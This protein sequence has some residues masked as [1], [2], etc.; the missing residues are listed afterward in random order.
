MSCK[1]RHLVLYNQCV[2]ILPKVGH[3]R[4][5]VQTRNILVQ[6]PFLLNH[7]KF[8][9]RTIAALQG[10]N[11]LCGGDIDKDG[12]HVR[13][14]ARGSHINT[15]HF[16]D[17][18]ERVRC[19]IPDFMK[20]FLGNYTLID[21]E[22]ARKSCDPVYCDVLKIKSPLDWVI[23]VLSTVGGLWTVIIGISTLAW[24]LVTCFSCMGSGPSSYK[25]SH[26]AK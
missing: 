7:N 6:V 18:T 8:L 15:S 5:D 3:L 19:Y 26:P 22:Q 20:W 4:A 24:T 2:T 25:V 11:Q 16:V 10:Y 14:F 23:E 12:F 13:S 17:G 21:G 1:S 9:N